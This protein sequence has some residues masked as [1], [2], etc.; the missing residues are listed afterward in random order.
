MGS[1]LLLRHCG[2]IY[3]LRRLPRSRLPLTKKF[4]QCSQYIWIEL[5]LVLELVFMNW[6][7]SFLL[8]LTNLHLC[9]HRRSLGCF[10]GPT[11]HC[12]YLP[13]HWPC[14]K[15]DRI[16]L[17]KTLIFS[18]SLPIVHL[19]VVISKLFVSFKIDLIWV[20]SRWS[21]GS[22]LCHGLWGSKICFRIMII[23]KTP[24][25]NGTTKS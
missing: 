3:K 2:Y 19:F 5:T 24:N 10:V 15:H 20:L 8:H 14:K 17:S 11:V 22:H 4:C 25:K 12:I 16:N 9:L 13:S 21:F 1:L 18:L 7:N 6:E 23:F